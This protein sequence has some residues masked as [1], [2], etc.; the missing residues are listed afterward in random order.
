MRNMLVNPFIETAPWWGSGMN[1]SMAKTT[2]V[3]SPVLGA[4]ITAIREK[5]WK[6]MARPKWAALHDIS[7]GTLAKAEKSDPSVSYRSMRKIADALGVHIGEIYSAAP[8]D[9][10][11]VATAP[12]WFTA[13][14]D[15]QTKAI[16]DLAKQVRDLAKTVERL[17]RKAR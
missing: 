14:L 16:T 13:A 10:A 12:A 2:D 11:P 3:Q 4:R 8:D 6:G 7:D 5:K 17:E 9:V 1:P 15:Q